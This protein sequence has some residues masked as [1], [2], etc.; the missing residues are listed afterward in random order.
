MK[1]TAVFF[2]SL[3]TE[4]VSFPWLHR[5]FAENAKR[6]LDIVKKDPELVSLLK[7]IYQDQLQE[8]DDFFA[9]MA[10]Y[11]GSCGDT[12]A[13][14]EPIL[15]KRTTANCLPHTLPDFLPSNITGLKKFPEAAYPYKDPA[16]SDQRGPC[17]GMNTLANH[18]YIPRNGIT[19]V[20]QTVVAAARVFNMGADLTTF[21]AGGSV[22][23]AGDI[24]TMRYS[25]GGA[26]KRT[27][28]AGALGSALGTETGLSGHLRFKE[29]DAS[30]TRCDFYLCDGDNHNMNGSIFKDLQDKAKTYG[31]GQYNVKALIHHSAAQYQNSRNNNPNFY[32]LPPSSALTIGATYFTAGFFSNGTIGYGGVANEAS[33]ASFDG[34]Y[35]NTNGTV[36][37]QPEQIPPQGWYRRG[38]PMFLSEGIDGIITL[39]TGVAAILG[40]PDLF[41]ANTGTA[42]DFNG[43]QSLA[44]FAGSGNYGGTTVNGT[45]CALEGALYGDF[46]SEFS[47]VL[48][49][50]V[51]ALN[52]VTSLFG[53]YGCPVPSGAPAAQGATTF[54]GY[55]KPSPCTLNRMQ[56]G[57]DQC[58]PDT[59]TYDRFNSKSVPF[60]LN[61]PSKVAASSNPLPVPGIF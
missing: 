59:N 49:T 29:G 26:D 28:S 20:A 58:A 34:A 31:G 10:D 33:I 13:E 30:G 15:E 9:A 36:S 4:S 24:P 48:S 16:P 11:T 45:I 5:D 17:P 12:E 57:L 47:N 56:N 61:S 19:T 55:P 44:S 41:G 23:F 25:I 43:Q 46:V 42:G 35:F 18:G 14:F 2:L 54:P 32:F 21:L 38:F 1:L 6:G 22:L 50:A 27:N 3:I 52:T 37:Y 53:Q 7:S 60:C 8:R 40:Q 39:Y 51:G